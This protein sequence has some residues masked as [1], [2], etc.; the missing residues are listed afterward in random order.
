MI[1]AVKQSLATRGEHAYDEAIDDVWHELL[2]AL[3]RLE[4]LAGRPEELRDGEQAARVRAL[5]YRLHAA[6]EAV[7]ALDPP[8]GAAAEHA[9]LAGAL[10]AGR[11]ATGEV[12]AALDDEAE[13]PLES[14]WLVTSGGVV[15]VPLALLLMRP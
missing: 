13:L 8:P 6:G 11:D 14:A 15:A 3:V 2:A 12:L 1:R 4:G 9:G 7:L 5:Q 10:E